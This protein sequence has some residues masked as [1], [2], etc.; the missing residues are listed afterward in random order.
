MSFFCDISTRYMT[1]KTCCHL[2]QFAW[3]ATDRSI[4]I[5]SAHRKQ[6]FE[7]SCSTHRINFRYTRL[8]KCNSLFSWAQHVGL[9]RGH[10]KLNVCCCMLH[11]CLQIRLAQKGCREIL[12]AIVLISPPGIRFGAEAVLVY[13]LISLDPTPCTL[14]E[15]DISYSPLHGTRKTEVNHPT[16]SKLLT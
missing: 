2:Q 9:R 1:V 14:R 12:V 8:L 11:Q 15:T 4:I 6:V 16:A 5:T 10:G 3:C 13:F 7:P